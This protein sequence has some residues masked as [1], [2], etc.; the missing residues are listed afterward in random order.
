MART[1]TARSSSSPPSSPRKGSLSRTNALPCS[2]SAVTNSCRRR[3]L[4]GRHVVFGEIL[5]GFDIIDKIEK[6]PT[7][8]GDKPIDTVKI[9]KSGELPVPDEGIHIEL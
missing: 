7:R 5:E 3:W 4:D 8:P 6:V 1:P 2:N 9:A